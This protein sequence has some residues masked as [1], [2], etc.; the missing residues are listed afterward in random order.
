MERRKA[1]PVAAALALGSMVMAAAAN[2]GLLTQ[3]RGSSLAQPAVDPA[4]SAEPVTAP[5]VEVR[6]EDVVVPV[7]AADTG[8]QTVAVATF[9]D[10]GDDDHD[11]H[12]DDDHDDD[13][14]DDDDD[15]DDSGRG[16]GRGR[17]GD[18]D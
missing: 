18:D 2:L 9:D 10:D 8:A 5:P 14:H 7:P 11:D 17:G 12:D 1:V 13:D 3:D 4:A 6:Y 16:R 15:D